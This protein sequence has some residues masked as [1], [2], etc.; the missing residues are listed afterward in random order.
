[1]AG[2]PITPS[3]NAAKQLGLANKGRIKAN[4][5]ADLVII[6]MDWNV[7]GTICRGTIAYRKK[8]IL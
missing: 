6:D 1:M 8:G 3:S 2:D 4:K 7:L 5:D